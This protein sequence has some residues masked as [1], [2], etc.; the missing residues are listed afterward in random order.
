MPSF[1]LKSDRRTWCDAGSTAGTLINSQPV[2]TDQSLQTGDTLQ[3]GQTQL[4]IDNDLERLEIE[5]D[6]LGCVHGGLWGFCD[7]ERHRLRAL[8][9]QWLQADLE[10]WT[11]QASSG[12]TQDLFLVHDTLRHWQQDANLQSV[13]AVSFCFAAGARTSDV[14]ARRI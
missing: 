6:Q 1:V 4:R 8:A 12:P 3:V 5:A 13:R 2:T 7:H 9:L 10:R 14:R 11:K